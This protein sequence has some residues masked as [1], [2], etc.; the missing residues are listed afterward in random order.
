MTM[1]QQQLKRFIQ[2]T[3]LHV[4][5]ERDVFTYLGACFGIGLAVSLLLIT[6]VLLLTTPVRADGTQDSIQHGTLFITAEGASERS[7]TPLLHTDVQFK[8]SGLIARAHVTQTFRNDSD[9][10][11]EG[12]YVFPLPENAA[13]D[14]LHM[15]VG[16]RSIEGVIQ[17]RAEAKRNYEQ[18]KQSGRKAALVEQER[19]NMFTNSVANIGPHDTVIVEIEYQQTLRYDQGDFHLRFPTTLTPR[20]I[21]GEEMG[22]CS[23]DDGADEVASDEVETRVDAALVPDSVN[24]V[25]DSA[26][27]GPPTLPANLQ[28]NPISLRIDLDAGFPLQRI[29]SPSHAI[30]TQ[31]LNTKHVSVTLAEGDVVSD[32]DFELVWTPEVGSAPHAAVFT[33]QRDDGFF[34]LLMILPPPAG[35]TSVTL[36]RETIFIIDTS[37][38]MAGTSMTQA[39]QALAMALERLHPTDRFDVIEFN[40]TTH[41]LFGGARYAS[42]DNLQRAQRFV[43]GLQANGGTE[44][45]PALRA[46]LDGRTH[47]DVLRQVIFLTD[48]SVGNEDAL[49]ELIQHRLGDSRLFTVGIGSAPSSYFMKKSAQFGHGTF[50]AIGD[51]KEVRARMSALFEKLEQPALTDIEVTWPTDTTLEYRPRTFPDLYAGEPLII[52]ARTAAALGEVSIHGTRGLQPWRAALP[53]HGGT[54]ASGVDV[55]WARAKIEALNDQV[56][57]GVD[58]AL[59]RQQVVDVALRHHLVSKYTSLLAV[60]VTPSRPDTDTLHTRNMPLNLPAG[61]VYNKVIGSLPQTAT[62]APLLLL[63]GG[64]LLF[65]GMTLRLRLRLA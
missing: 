3:Q 24:N 31:T 32:H 28:L 27:I 13:V 63:A 45:A 23:D 54:T 36:P 12:V 56:Q 51:V 59:L 7:E 49:F 35:T 4:P 62:P 46:A 25:P 47:H 58:A 52:S 44:M 30:V 64:L 57:A 29:D 17:E 5:L 10:W 15:K 16:T 11:V 6:L 2:L 14:H 8:V 20:Y 34:H 1:Q 22:G 42:V 40:S 21:P 43:A 26:R 9:A 65:C 33:E 38:S 19:P 60:D 37:G 53:L 50:T 18:A 48:G 61:M 55:V 41:V 39:K